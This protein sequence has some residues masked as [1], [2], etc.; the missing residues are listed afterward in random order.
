VIELPL[1]NSPLNCKLWGMNICPL[2]GGL[3]S[4][5]LQNVKLKWSFLTVFHHVLLLLFW[6]FI[7]FSISI[8]QIG[9][10][11]R[12]NTSVQKCIFFNTM[13]GSVRFIIFWEYKREMSNKIFYDVC[14][15]LSQGMLYLEVW[16]RKQSCRICTETCNP[17]G[18][19]WCMF[20]GSTI[21]SIA[22]PDGCLMHQHTGR[23][24]W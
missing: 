19:K 5:L 18:P 23:S 16:W 7:S 4:S 1:L 11:F 21:K 17:I 12:H 13:I 10:N 15:L 6:R 2:L 22:V 8:S 3:R 20:C 9:E 24:H 14:D